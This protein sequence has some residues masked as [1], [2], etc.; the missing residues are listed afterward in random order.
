MISDRDPL[1]E[2]AKVGVRGQVVISKKLY[3]KL[4]IE[5]GLEIEETAKGL[6]LK[7]YNPAANLKGLGKNH[8][9]RTN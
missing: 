1:V 7:P 6:L 8:L 4:S 2:K 5:H 3:K 9:R